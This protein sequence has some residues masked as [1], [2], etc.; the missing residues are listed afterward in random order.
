M[1]KAISL[2]SRMASVQLACLRMELRS[3]DL[4]VALDR[5]TLPF[6]AFSRTR[7]LR[8]ALS[9]M[10]RLFEALSR[11]AL[12]RANLR[13]SPLWDLRQKVNRGIRRKARSAK[14]GSSQ[15]TCSENLCRYLYGELYH[16]LCHDACH[17]Y[18]GD[19]FLDLCQDSFHDS[20]F[21]RRLEEG[22]APKSRCL[23]INAS[24]GNVHEFLL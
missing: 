3:A 4:F 7:R 11:A 13:S 12:S 9:W 2:E 14:N 24:V 19:V 15:T 1:R 10:T 22:F 18:Q 23:W 8:L 5:V 21:Y 6:V 20:R 17:D 16:S